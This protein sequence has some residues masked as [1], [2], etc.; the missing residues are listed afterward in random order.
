MVWIYRV[1]IVNSTSQSEVQY[2]ICCFKD[3]IAKVGERNVTN[4]KRNASTFVLNSFV[5]SLYMVLPA[6]LISFSAKDYFRTTA[7]L[8]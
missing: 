6:I 4:K 2:L 7:L 5:T 1:M 8:A 3:G